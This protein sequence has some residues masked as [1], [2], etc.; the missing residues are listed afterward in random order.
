MRTEQEN[1]AASLCHLFNILPL[2]GLLTAGAIWFQLREESRRVVLHA[3]QAMIFNV[4]GLALVL[5]WL[6]VGLLAKVVKYVSLPL[7]QGLVLVNNGIL[8]VLG[9][10]YVIICLMGFARCLGG[11]SFHYPLIKVE[12]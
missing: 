6:L 2:W 12:R 7:G 4:M 8:L 1:L 3:Q 9:A 5:I 10:A 11:Q